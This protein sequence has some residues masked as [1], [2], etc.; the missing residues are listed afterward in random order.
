[1]GGS[2]ATGANYDAKRDF[3]RTPEPPMAPAAGAEAGIP[4]ADGTFVIHRHEARR[5]HYDLRMATDRVL[6]CWA[7]PRGF[8]YDP[9]VKHLAVHTEDHPLRYR[10]FEGVIPKGEY[11]AGTMLIWD[12][13][14]Y[15]VLK[16]DDLAAAIGAGEVKVLLRGRRLRGEWHLVRTRAGQGGKDEWLLF[17]ARDRYVRAAD[18]PAPPMV[19]AAR[20]RPAPLPRRAR[21]MSAAGDHEQFSD[22][23]WLFELEFDGLRTLATVVDGDVAFKRPTGAAAA[24]PL[25]VRA[26]LERDFARVRASQA[27]LDGVLVALDRHGRPAR[28]ALD[29]CVAAL[30]PGHGAG[31][32]GSTAGRAG[33]TNTATG[34]PAA[35]DRV[36]PNA[37]ADTA[38]G[39]TAAGTGSAEETPERTA[40]TPT[41]TV[42]YY[43]FDLLHYD[44]WD[45]RGLPLAERKQFLR[46]LVPELPTVLYADHVTASGEGLAAVAAGAGFHGL[47]AKHAASTYQPGAHSDWRR[48][49][50]KAAAEARDVEVGAALA[51]AT[52]RQRKHTDIRFS[53]LDKVFWPREGYTKGHL[54]AF[55]ERIADYLLPYLRD[56]P[57]H[58]N[59]FPDGIGG[60]SFFQRQAPAGVP[61]WVEL[62]EVDARHTR[63]FICNDLR[64]LLYLVNLG[65]IEL[66]PW[67]SRRGSLAVPDFA[68]LD[69]DAK[70]AEFGTAVRVARTAGRVLRGIGLRPAIKT[71]GASGLHIYVP[72]VAGYRYE[73]VRLFMEAVARVVAR[74]LP[75]IASVERLPRGR[76]G[77]VYVD[78]LQNRRSATV[79]PPYVARPVPG[80][81]VSMPLEWDELDGDLHPRRFSIAN[82]AEIVARRGDL[83]RSTL[84]DRQDFAPAIDKLQLF[85]ADPGP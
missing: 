63:Q 15:E 24:V 57:V 59:R 5:L 17:K 74:E 3:A 58:M 54:L 82:A 4:A 46:S 60:K 67:L 44:E 11:G 12:T 47:V 14:S 73:Q 76:G 8:S 41:G 40:A 32:C 22:P 80:A 50:L 34:A 55:Y 27:L 2:R 64:T 29:G 83:F 19:D 85:L 10:T 53:N 84:T 75:D 31:A 13:G 30:D 52:D 18:E 62:V 61:D 77:K 43:A 81:Q 42:A 25:P 6:V 66:H 35:V 65:S 51:A 56:R 70:E 20:A 48:I 28:D 78:F 1:M 26:A 69:L 71:S 16:A 45:L 21:A 9:T 37:G 7:V 39:D 23:D 49:P 36:Q 79:V 33:R 68:V 72:L 38:A